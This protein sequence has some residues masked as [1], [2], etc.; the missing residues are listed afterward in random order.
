MSPAD[1]AV[2]PGRCLIDLSE[3][4]PA[5]HQIAQGMAL[6]PAARDQTRAVFLTYKAERLLH[7]GEIDQGAATA[8]Q[9]LHLAQQISASRCV[10]QIHNLAPGFQ[11]HPAVEGIGPFL[12]AVQSA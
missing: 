5:R 8:R 3:P 10:S 7:Q 6:L 11:K 12:N 1:V 9:A 2:D 4:G